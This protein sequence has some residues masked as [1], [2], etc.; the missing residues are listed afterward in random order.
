[1]IYTVT[2]NPGLDRTL[3]TAA[4]RYNEVLR[5]S[6]SRL[7]WGG[8]G[9]NVS[10]A[11]KAL[12]MESVA[13][14]FVGGATGQMLA[15]GLAGL[16]IA[17]EFITVEGETRTNTVIE[18]EGSG[19]YIKV[20]EPGPHIPIAAQDALLAR[21]REL[22][23]PGS[24]WVLAGSLPPGVDIAFYARLVTLVQARGGRACLDTSGEALRLG[25]AA[26]PHLVKPNTE[27]AREA[28]GRP[29]HTVAE[30]HA[31][32][33]AFLDHGVEM[34]ALSLG[35]DGLALVT[36]ARALHA[37]PPQVQART[38]VGVG[39]VLLAGLIWAQEHGLD[40]SETAR[41]AVAAGTAAAIQDGVSVP[42][43]AAVEAMAGRV[44]V[45]PLF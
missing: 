22:V 27:E 41:W 39:D 34:A 35:A 43:R 23:T 45:E 33:R 37:R 21:L 16:G 42:D 29:V 14:G 9:F 32:A 12:G 10:R 19:R 1:M 8:K 11:L 31:A 6:A 28:T 26:S 15:R 7:D 36:G 40:L 3:T 2:L 17:T 25:C 20:N 24:V 38:V 44:E 18:E 13:V 30:A 4:I 5:A